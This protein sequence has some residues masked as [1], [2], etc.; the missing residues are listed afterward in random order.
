MKTKTISKKI[1]GLLLAFAMVFSAFAM[2]GV[3]DVNAADDAY[4][5]VYVAPTGS[6]SIADAKVA[7]E[8]T[9]SEF[10]AL[11]NTNEMRTLYFKGT[12]MRVHISTKH[13]AVTSLL[14]NAGISNFWTEGSTMNA[15]DSGGLYTKSSLGYASGVNDLNKYVKFYGD[16]TAEYGQSG[17]ATTI[18]PSISIEGYRE[19]ITDAENTEKA[20]ELK[21]KTHYVSNPILLPGSAA[22][23]TPLAGNMFPNNMK[24]I[25]VTGTDIDTINLTSTGLTNAAASIDKEYVDN[26]DS[27]AKATVTVKPNSNYSFKVAP[28]VSAADGGIVAT[29]ANGAATVGDAVKGTDGSYTFEI[30]GFSNDYPTVNLTVTGEAV[31]NAA[32]EDGDGS[33]SGSTKTGD[34]SMIALFAMLMIIA[35]GGVFVAVRK[36]G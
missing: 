36:R 16:T 32:D 7:K 35:A 6:T 18:T 23:G 1:L 31:A 21:E 9:K 26:K 3:Q 5:T 8:Y 2:L 17:E 33:A 34:E 11:C 4:F 27:N 28:V 30:S 15:V 24:G 22:V 12:T 20:S 29:V 14:N 13:V 25:M 10:E 19:D